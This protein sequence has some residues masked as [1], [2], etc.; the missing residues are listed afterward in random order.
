M[1]FDMLSESIPPIDAITA[2]MITISKTVTKPFLWRRCFL[3]EWIG[4]RV[5]L[6]PFVCA[7]D[8]RAAMGV[9]AGSAGF[10]DFV[11]TPVAS[12]AAWTGHTRMVCVDQ[13]FNMVWSVSPRVD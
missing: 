2:M 8:Y 11:A 1:M 12:F 9:L 4:T 3:S 6:V 13:S 7:A 10:A 5:W